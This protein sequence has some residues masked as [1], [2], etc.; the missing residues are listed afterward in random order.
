VE[1]LEECLSQHV[2]HLVWGG[3]LHWGCWNEL[4]SWGL[5]ARWGD[6]RTAMATLIT[7]M[8]VWLGAAFIWEYQYSYLLSLAVSL[9]VYLGV[10]LAQGLERRS[11]GSQIHPQ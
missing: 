7:G 1:Q 5:F 4:P 2:C 3:N 8:A 6:A 9:V 10:A 11:P